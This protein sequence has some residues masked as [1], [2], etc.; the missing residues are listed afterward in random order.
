MIPVKLNS[1][2]PSLVTISN[3]L[4]WVA[5]YLKDAF[6]NGLKGLQE[7]WTI[8]K[9][10]FSNFIGR[11][12]Q[13]WLWWPLFIHSFF[14]IISPINKW[15][16]HTLK[17]KVLK[18][19]KLR[20]IFCVEICTK[21]RKYWKSYIFKLSTVWTD[22]AVFGSAEIVCNFALECTFVGQNR[23]KHSQIK[24]KNFYVSCT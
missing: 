23:L 2:Y 22:G 10:I 13:L 12:F 19:F 17:R 24:K 11:T 9:A 6:W 18:W 3:A 21:Y 1:K 8:L 4:V 7:S 15:L 14:M 5:C 20:D 16:S